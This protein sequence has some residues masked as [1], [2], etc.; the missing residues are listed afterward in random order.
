MAVKNEEDEKTP[1]PTA[2]KTPPP[3][4]SRCPPPPPVS[5]RTNVYYDEKL[6]VKNEED[7]VQAWEPCEQPSSSVSSPD[8]SSGPT[9]ESWSEIN[10]LMFT[11]YVLHAKLPDTKS[12]QGLLQHPGAHI[13]ALICEHVHGAEWTEIKRLAKE[14]VLEGKTI[15][16]VCQGCF[17]VTLDRMCTGVN[18]LPNSTMTK[19]GFTLGV[20]EVTLMPPQPA[21]VIGLLNSPL[22]QE[23][24]SGIVLDSINNCI[25][26]YGI[27]ILSGIFPNC[28]NDSN[29]ARMLCQAGAACL[30]LRQPFWGYDGCKYAWPHQVVLFGPANK[31]FAVA[32]D[33]VPPWDGMLERFDAAGNDF[34]GRLYEQ[35]TK[36][37]SPSPTNKVWAKNL[38]RARIAATK[39][40]SVSWQWWIAGTHQIVLWIDG[41]SGKERRG[42]GAQEKTKPGWQPGLQPGGDQRENDGVMICERWRDDVL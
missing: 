13:N 1:W 4:S 39:Q 6:A 26:K 17:V 15:H 37:E 41:R 23:D 42:A 40:K 22:S 21:V 7:G 28:R 16:E 24:P 31:V 35:M 18:L 9:N 30:P 34:L 8:R 11:S 14:Q 25:D 2:A 29:L 12:L 19:F 38:S 33:D 27:R 32:D 5:K 10:H 3:P 20:V 36:V